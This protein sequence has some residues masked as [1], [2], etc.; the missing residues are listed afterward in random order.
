MSNSVVC[1]GSPNSM[2]ASNQKLTVQAGSTLTGYW[3]HELGSTGP[4]QYADNKVIDS[5]HK[6]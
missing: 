6:V 3:L 4:D 2:R 1:N 5:S